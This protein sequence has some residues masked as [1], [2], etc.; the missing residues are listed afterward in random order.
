[1]HR[2]TNV[3]YSM[4]VLTGLLHSNSEQHIELGKSRLK[5]DNSD[6]EKLIN[7]FDIHE[8]FNKIETNL[9]CLASGLTA[10]EE[11]D[12]EDVG[13]AIHFKLDNISV[14]DAKIKRTDQVRTIGKLRPGIKIDGKT[15][16]IDPTLLFIRLTALLGPQDDVS[17]KFDFELTPE[18]TA[19]FK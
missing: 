8:P 9:K 1:M 19:L 18:P 5:R 12:A 15:T 3:H 10:A 2:C 11:D 16:H 6:L 17:K 4:S 13:R 7:W 14:K